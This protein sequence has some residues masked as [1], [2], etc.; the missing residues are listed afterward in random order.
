MP[1]AAGLRRA[2]CA[3]NFD[4]AWRSFRCPVGVETT[5]RRVA[6]VNA[7]QGWNASSPSAVI[8]GSRDRTASPVVAACAAPRR[9]GPAAAGPFEGRPHDSDHL[10]HSKCAR[11]V[12]PLV[13]RAR[14]QR[15]V[16]WQKN[17]SLR[18]R[19]RARR[20]PTVVAPRA[21]S[22]SARPTR[23]ARRVTTAAARRT[24]FAS[25]TRS[26]PAV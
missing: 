19:R 6:R 20:G 21:R 15:S 1:T 12:A 13:E 16:R 8:V 9:A 7:V 22:S 2:R 5:G 23:S 17:Y 3:S 26:V 24:G 14:R 18:R 11:V 4:S 25:R 10:A